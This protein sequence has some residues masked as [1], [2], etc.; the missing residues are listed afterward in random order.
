MRKHRNFAVKPF[1]IMLASA[2]TAMSAQAEDKPA[3]EGESLP[4]V[5]VKAKAPPLGAL[6]GTY[7]GGQ[8][9]RGGRIGV[10][11]NQD[12]MD[13]PFSMTSY[14]S[15][16]IEDQ[17]AKTIADV[18]I[19]D[20]SVR[21]GQSFGTAAQT[22]VIRGYPVLSEDVSFNG[23]YGITPRQLP[24]IEG[25][26]RLEVFKGANAFLNGVSP[27]GS[28]IGGTINIVPKRASDI[29]LTRTTL[30]YSSSG[31]I[32][33]HV[34]LGRRFGVDNQFGL[35]LN[36]VQRDG[37]TA[38]HHEDS[39]LTFATLGLDFTGE[40]L[41]LS[42]DLSY[43]KQHITRPRLAVNVGA[44]VTNMPNAP[45]SKTNY[46]QPWSYTSVE[47]TSAVF[48]GEYD[49]SSRIMGYAAI[50]FGHNNEM[51]DLA[52][53]TITSNNG[54][55]ATSR[56]ANPYD[57]STTSSEAGIKVNFET[58]VVKHKVNIGATTTQSNARSNFIFDSIA[59]ATS[60]YDPVNVANPDGP[61]FTGSLNDP[62]I[63]NRV[64][65]RSFALADT[66]SFLDDKI[67]LTLGL[68]RQ[69]IKV[70]N[71]DYFSGNE[72][73]NSDK[74]VT[75]P[76][77]GVVV[78]PWKFVSL[79]ANHIEGL[80]QGPVA[81]ATVG[82]PA[83]PVA[84]AGQVLP[85]SKSRQN[86]IGV[87]VDYGN[88]GASLAVFEIERPNSTYVGTT[89]TNDGEQRNRGIE[90]NAYGEPITGWRVLGGA[91]F[92]DAELTK[93]ENGTNDG[94]TSYGVPK[95]QY[96]FG[97]EFDVA[98]IPGFTVTGRYIRTGSQF[99]NQTNTLN[100]PSWERFDLGARYATKLNDHDVKFRANIENL[101]DKDYWAAVSPTFGQVT[102]G[103]PR[104]IRLSATFD[105]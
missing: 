38:I 34:D 68:R 61:S 15:K 87:K 99:V 79:Y 47:S 84:N 28:G 57:V 60:I 10:L 22:F 75:T 56:F 52:A 89:F 12:I 3:N 19:N 6:P 55:A 83:V 20:P 88:V 36:A 100:I 4:E 70:I 49:I 67:F 23:L 43:Q 73:D 7:A 96:N 42:A 11:G 72:S 82:F 86:E 46:S 98:G 32:G 76:I 91:A 62:E 48:R 65:N 41:R 25:V 90:F 105:F 18:L 24:T 30:D 69:S 29:P 35:R 2:L 16:I 78:K 45:D 21:A 81:P 27:S 50:G 54:G 80:S 40:D 97:T 102:M 64:R 26:E 63:I 95:N 14:T 94:N 92:T 44:A 8:I 13:V 31:Q 101:F 1:V 104:T 77:Y 37:N 93:T 59:T 71:Y 51:N 66:L 103:A 17:Q 53:L 5:S 39:R 9:A 58:G 85:P 33:G 74:S